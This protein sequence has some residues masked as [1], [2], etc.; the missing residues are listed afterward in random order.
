MTRYLCSLGAAAA[1]GRRAK[2]KRIEPK[3]LSP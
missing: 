2:L 1:G 3:A